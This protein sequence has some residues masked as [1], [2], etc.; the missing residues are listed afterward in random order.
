MR[1]AALL[2]RFDGIDRVWLVEYAAT[3]STP[4]TYGVADLTALGFHE[5][6]TR[7]PTHHALV[8]LYERTR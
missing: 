5:T 4:D 6:T 2:G 8:A 1:R 7:I 3:P